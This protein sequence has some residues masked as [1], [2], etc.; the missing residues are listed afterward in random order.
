MDVLDRLRPEGDEGFTL[1]ET[2]AAMI[3]F[4]ILAVSVGGVILH[5]FNLTKSNT[6]RVAAA[7][8]ATQRIE[9][10]RALRALD[11]PDGMSVVTPKP[12][13]NGVEYTVTQTANYVA[14]S[15]G[16]SLCSGTTSSGTKLA[17][18][19]V[20]VLVTWP[21][22]GSVQP[23]RQDTLLNL[24]IGFNGVATDKGTGAVGVVDEAGQP[25][26]GVTVTLT[27]SSVQRLTG[28]DGCAVFTGLA[29]GTSY[30]ATAAA[31]GFVSPVGAPTATSGTFTVTASGVTRVPVRYQRA[32]ALAATLVAPGGLVPPALLELTLSSSNFPT[33]ERIF[34]DCSSVATSPQ[35][36]VSGQPRTASALFPGQYG[37][38]PGSCSDAKPSSPVTAAV[39]PAQ[40]TPV[41]LPLA[42]VVVDVRD[43]MG[44]PLAGK[45]VYA[46]HAAD[47]GCLSGTV[48]P[49]APA[50]AS[51]Q[52]LALPPGTW[53]FS[54]SPTLGTGG[55]AVTLTAGVITSVVMVTS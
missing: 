27:P 16:S 42:G 47:T 32:G 23:V 17:Y 4:A 19:L 37:V 21:N 36:C 45:T 15:S 10:T 54:F 51:S 30:T 18:K 53:S 5:T 50:G 28:V 26:A 44:K 49:L 1:V 35:Y 13:V 31:P 40:S 12:V 9:Q 14:S 55:A 38:W 2:L 24:G 41:S 22:M 8:L 25:V 6:S 43:S 11:V 33:P 39:R 34:A 7:N 3:V 29:P 20:T 52:S 46:L 48:W